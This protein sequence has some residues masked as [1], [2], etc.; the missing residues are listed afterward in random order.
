MCLS[1]YARSA[2]QLVD[3]LVSQTLGVVSKHVKGGVS[4]WLDQVNFPQESTQQISNYMTETFT[5]PTILELRSFIKSEIDQ[6]LEK[7]KNSKKSVK[8]TVDLFKSVA[9]I[10]E[11]ITQKIKLNALEWSKVHQKLSNKFEQ[12]AVNHRPGLAKRMTKDV[13]NAENRK[14]FRFPHLFDESTFTS[15]LIDFFFNQIA[16]LPLYNIFDNTFNGIM[17]LFV[18][19]N[20]MVSPLFNRIMYGYYLYTD[21]SQD[22]I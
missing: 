18:V 22:F 20:F 19:Q 2:N 1:V 12:R 14:K 8:Q 9:S 3:Q 21:D 13:K 4:Q 7:T 6:V 15:S 17:S 5:N 11:K 16:M 10:S